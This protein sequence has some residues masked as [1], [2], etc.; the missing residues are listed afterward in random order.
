M[1][2]AMKRRTGFS[3]LILV[4]AALGQT[5][6]GTARAQDD[7]ERAS[8]VLGAFITDRETRTRLDSDTSPGTDIELENELGLESSST[9]FR[10]GGYYWMRPRHRI[11]FSVFDLSRSATKQ[12]D[13]TIN[14]GDQVF[15][16]NTFV[17]TSND[18]TILKADYTFAVVNREQGFLGLTG[19][20]Y[21]ADT[22][23][24]L[25]ERTLGTF[26]SEDLTAPLPV[27]GF[28]GEYE[29]SDRV[30]LRGAA[31]WFSIDAGDVDGSLRDIYL[32]VDYGFNDRMAIGL[33]YNDVSLDV[34]ATESGGFEG[35]LDW[36][37]DGFLLYFKADFGSQ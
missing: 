9:V 34:N 7:R 27:V 15:N 25:R 23:L 22:K 36:G 8:I 33:A 32:G 6:P 20:L 21:V 19:G 3:L 29:I 14:F 5:L 10:I 16:I 11:D 37:Y 35:A 28:R 12:I 31:Q 2:L 18:L 1:T 13:E 30:S 26:E 17:E 4:T 24:A